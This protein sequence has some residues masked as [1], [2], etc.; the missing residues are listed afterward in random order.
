MGLAVQLSLFLNLRILLNT[1]RYLANER[2][3]T[4]KYTVDRGGRGLVGQLALVS[5]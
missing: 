4:A 1:L 3:R 5:A 2:T